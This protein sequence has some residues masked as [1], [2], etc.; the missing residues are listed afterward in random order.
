MSKLDSV[1][2]LLSTKLEGANKVSYYA[3][4]T[5]LVLY[6]TNGIQGRIYKK[7]NFEPKSRFKIGK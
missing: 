6:K 1:S 7:Q 3:C 4:L 5:G 2:F